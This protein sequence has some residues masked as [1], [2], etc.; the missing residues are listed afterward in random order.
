MKQAR[1]ILMSSVWTASAARDHLAALV[2]A[3]NEGQPQVIHGRGG[4]KA[5]LI[6]MEQFCKVRHVL[7][8]SLL[9]DGVSPE[10]NPCDNAYHEARGLFRGAPGRKS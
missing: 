2:D 3:A 10:D 6:S 4:Q 5:V 9:P 7:E 1:S 8:R